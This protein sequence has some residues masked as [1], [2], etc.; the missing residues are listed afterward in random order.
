MQI[1]NLTAAIKRHYFHVEITSAS[2][3]SSSNPI[4]SRKMTSSLFFG[5]L[6][7]SVIAVFVAA[8]SKTGDAGSVRYSSY[9]WVLIRPIR[10]TLCVVRD[11]IDSE[12]IEYVRAMLLPVVSLKGPMVSFTLLS[13]VFLFFFRWRLY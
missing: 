2:S 8:D 4:D 5:P 9:G 11:R 7:I 12:E 6:L 3:S 13:F 10:E 1:H